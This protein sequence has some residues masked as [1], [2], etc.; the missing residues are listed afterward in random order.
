MY[1]KLKLSKEIIPSLD[2]NPLVSV[3]VD[4]YNYARY[5]SQA[6]DSALNQSYENFE[7]I[8][9]DDGSTDNSKEIMR[10]YEDKIISIYKENGGQASAFNAGFSRAAG[11]IICLLDPDD[12]FHPDKLRHVVKGFH[13]NPE[14]IQIINPWCLVNKQGETIR[15]AGRHNF[16]KGD[17]R[18]TV[19]KTG[20][21]RKA[22]TS[23]AL[24]LRREILEYALPIPESEYVKGGV[25]GY[26][27]I[28]SSFYGKVGYINQLAT[29][30]R[31]H[32]EN[33]FSRNPNLQYRVD[34]RI[35]RTKLINQ[36]AEKTGLNKKYQL[37]NDAE[38]RRL[39]IIQDGHTSSLNTLHT[40]FLTFRNYFLLHRSFR[41]T[42]AGLLQSMVVIA[43]PS[44]F[45][46]VVQRG[47]L[48]YI[49]EKIKI[50]A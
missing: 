38:Y 46:V 6:I 37:E 28:S 11:Q 35:V 4:N 21:Y 20:Q 33:T 25:D 22:A 7:V 50:W 5:L 9:V 32:G 12:Y 29:Y 48:R 41:E 47:T 15:M 40:I 3:V 34:K 45:G 16:S 30:Y 17:V 18:K 19:L 13:D 31:I 36:L 39:T 24:S 2:D 23:S 43:A 44:K 49:L 14:W 10:S 27:S 26:L 1:P 8:V 42:A